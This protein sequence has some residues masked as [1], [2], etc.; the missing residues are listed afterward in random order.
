MRDHR[1]HP[2]VRGDG[3]DDVGPQ[4][5]AKKRRV[6]IQ[7]P[8]VDHRHHETRPSLFRKPRTRQINVLGEVTRQRDDFFCL[9]ECPR[10]KHPEPAFAVDGERCVGGEFTCQRAPTK[11]R[12]QSQG[13][14]DLFEDDMFALG[15]VLKEVIDPRR[16]RH[17]RMSRVGHRLA[18]LNPDASRWFCLSAFGSRPV[19]CR[20]QVSD[21]CLASPLV[22]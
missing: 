20:S 13:L 17:R 16:Q 19:T 15:S 22:G 4:R 9:R 7:C 2:E 1:H 6:Q 3:G 10:W 5:Q 8:G 11:D 12:R 14:P 18:Y 21:H